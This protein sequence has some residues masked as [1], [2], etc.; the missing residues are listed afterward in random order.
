MGTRGFIGWKIDGTIVTSYNHL[1][2]YPT[3]LGLRTIKGVIELVIAAGEHAQRGVL[4]AAE[5]PSTP[6]AAIAVQTDERAVALS[7]LRDQF[8]AIRTVDESDEP[9]PAD[10]TKYAHLTDGQVSR[11]GEDWYSVLR[12]LQGDLA[13]A[14]RA[15][16]ITRAHED[17]PRDSLFCEWGYLLDLDQSEPVLEVYRGFRQSPPAGG[18]WK[19]EPANAGGYYPVDLVEAV[20]LRSL[21]VDAE[22]QAELV[23]RWE[24]FEFPAAAGS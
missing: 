10:R 1:D 18:R 22:Q 16:I 7:Y 17:W 24:A 9:D 11:K 8:R 6:A 14:A 13:G 19:G 3:W 21:P 5:E 20:P 15:R 4:A 2:S 12:N 23:Q